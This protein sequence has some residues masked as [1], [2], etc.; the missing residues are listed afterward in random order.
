MYSELSELYNFN[1]DWLYRFTPSKND[2]K[3]LKLCDTVEAIPETNSD[4][5]GKLNVCEDPTETILNVFPEKPISNVWSVLSKPFRLDIPEPEP[6][7][8][9]PPVPANVSTQ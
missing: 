8:G 6:G 3:P 9:S 1:S 2:F 4:A 5:Y 7:N